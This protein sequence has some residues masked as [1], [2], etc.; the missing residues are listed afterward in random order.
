LVAEGYKMDVLFT[1]DTRSPIS[2]DLVKGSRL[3]VAL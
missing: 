2:L 3:L 1:L